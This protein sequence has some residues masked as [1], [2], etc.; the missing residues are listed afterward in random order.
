M[1]TGLDNISQR[2]GAENF[3]HIRVL[4][5]RIVDLAPE[6][7]SSHVDKLLQRVNE[8]EHFLKRDY[9]SHLATTSPCA[10]HC[11]TRLLGGERHDYSAGCSACHKAR[12]PKCKG[13]QD[14]FIY[15]NDCPETCGD[16]SE[17]CEKCDQY[18]LIFA[19]LHCMLQLAGGLP[20]GQVKMPRDEAQGS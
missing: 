10:A 6:V 2:Y 4:V 19:E 7:L 12:T 11:L 15:S 17:H 14:R 13:C 20:A 18:Y 8:Y 5:Q 16:H 9:T 3:Q 1:L